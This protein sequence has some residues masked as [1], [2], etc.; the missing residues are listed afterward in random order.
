[1]REQ[2][3]NKQ[4]GN[5]IIFDEKYFTSQKSTKFKFLYDSKSKNTVVLVNIERGTSYEAKEFYEFV[6]KLINKGQN[7]LIIDLEGI[8]FIDSVFFGTLVKLLKETNKANGSMS[9]IV[10]Y[11]NRP[12]ILTINQLEGIFNTYPNLFEALNHDKFIN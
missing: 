10:N 1:M 9:L 7:K 11:K 4:S 2:A 8:Y 3:I 6:T 12:E 5:Q